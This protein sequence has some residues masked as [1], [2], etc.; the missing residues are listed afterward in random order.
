MLYTAARVTHGANRQGVALDRDAL[1]IIIDAQE[2]TLIR[3][4][5]TLRG[6][7]PLKVIVREASISRFREF[8]E[9][10]NPDAYQ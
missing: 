8:G 1:E 7:A 3:D 4:A 6:N 10:Y 2:S 5:A 9:A